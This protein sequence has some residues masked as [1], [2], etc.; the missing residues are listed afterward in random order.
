MSWT[1]K[2]SSFVKRQVK[3]SGKTYSDTLSFEEIAELAK[4][5][6]NQNDTSY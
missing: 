5:K 3:G 2:A 4:E 6:I 1:V